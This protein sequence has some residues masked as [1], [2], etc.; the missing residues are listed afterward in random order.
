MSAYLHSLDKL[1]ALCARHAVRALLPAHGHV[2]LGARGHLARIKAHRLAREARVR[3]AMQ[4]LPQGGLD[5]WLPLAYADVPQ[6]A[7]PAARKSLL[8][9]VLRLRQVAGENAAESP[10]QSPGRA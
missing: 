4:A 5:D 8:A 2:L 3:A 9:H 1:D 7:W 10:Q 6:S